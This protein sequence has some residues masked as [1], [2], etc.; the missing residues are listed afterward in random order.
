MA[1]Y[2]RLYFDF[3]NIY[4]KKRSKDFTFR[5]DY[6]DICRI[7]LGGLKVLRFKAKI[8][9]EQLG[10]HCEALKKRGLIKKYEIEKNAAQDG[11]NIVF[12]PGEGF[13][14]DYERFYS[15]KFQTE[16]PF[17]LAYDENTIQKPQEAVRYFYQKLYGTDTVSDIA[18]SEKETSFA[19]SLFERHNAEEIRTFVDYGLAE[20]TKTNFDIK[21]FG[22]LKKYYLP[23]T[24]HL[25]ARARTTTKE[26][27][28]DEKRVQE[29]K[30]AAYDFYRQEEVAKIRGALS[31]DEIEAIENRIREELEAQHSGAKIFSGWIRQRA[32]RAIAEKHG[33]LS[34]EEW[35]KRCG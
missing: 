35:Q 4:S 19:S 27:E 34:F 9:K 30:L 21:T 13:F 33:V 2:K 23:Y 29:R 14:E 7:W 5:K 11:F 15:R 18:L 32:D 16:L 31:L 8:L 1:L 28:E 6:A 12:H 25:T 17:T 22:G 3:S 24:K 10:R 26:A 20:A